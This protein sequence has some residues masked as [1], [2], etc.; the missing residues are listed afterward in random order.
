MIENNKEF[1]DK[2]EWG[3]NEFIRSL[4]K[5]KNHVCEGCVL[6]ALK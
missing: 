5:I 3:G 6:S 2:L 1:V 4:Y